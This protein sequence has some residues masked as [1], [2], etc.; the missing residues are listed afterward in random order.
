VKRTIPYLNG[1]LLAYAEYGD[2]TG[3]PILIQHGM[4]ASIHD[5]DLFQ[6]LVQA[7]KR[8]IFMARP[9][10][11]ES[12]PYEMANIAEWGEVAA[13]LVDELDLR[14]FDVFGMS[15]GAPYSYAIGRRYP[16]RA[17][18]IY[19]FSGIPALY[20]AEVLAHWPYPV[21]KAATIVELE[22]V[23]YEL[24]FSNLSGEDLNK[25]SG[26]D[27]M[28]N[29]CFG[30]AQDLKLRCLD[31]GFRL[32]DVSQNVTMRHGRFDEAVPYATAERTASL[33][34]NCV[35]ETKDTGVHFS[36]DSLADFMRTAMLGARE[37]SSFAL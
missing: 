17:H 25:I 18:N 35:L 31:W 27:S 16:D 26:R 7:G 37:G 33:L 4:V 34:P 30:I 10:Y 8:L 36:A 12:T 6:P 28:R 23:A 13:A 1:Q 3:Y 21:D 15:S 5:G 32:S 19:I 24:F 29:G 9:G 14:D 2:P 22:R 20:D 11:G